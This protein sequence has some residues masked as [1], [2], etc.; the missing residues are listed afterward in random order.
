[1]T[2]SAAEILLLIISVAADPFNTFQLRRWKWDGLP[3][4]TKA[5][6]ILCGHFLPTSEI[7][8]ELPGNTGSIFGTFFVAAKYLEHMVSALEAFGEE[9]EVLIIPIS[10]VSHGL[11]VEKN[12]AA[13]GI[14]RGQADIKRCVTIGSKVDSVVEPYVEANS[15]FAVVLIGNIDQ[16]I[17]IGRA[18]SER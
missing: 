14:G 1:M 7:G 2:R 11:S 5:V 4:M 15:A 16:A 18:V 12:Q 8:L 9:L 6:Q 13:K 17:E 10:V 3:G